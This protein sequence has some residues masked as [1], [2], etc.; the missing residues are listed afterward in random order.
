MAE[1]QMEKKERSGAAWIW[2]LLAVLLIA[3]LVWWLWP[4]RNG[5]VE[6]AAVETT[7]VTTAPL[8]PVT[9]EPT[10]ALINANP[11]EWVG[12]E[13]SGTVTVPEVPTDRGFWI[14]QDGQRLF[15]LLVDRESEEP[16]NINP[17]QRL[18]IRGTVRDATHLAQLQGDPLTGPTEE[19]VR[20]QP[21]YL[22]AGETA[23]EILDSPAQ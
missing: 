9:S 13:F 5:I 4:T 22:V 6:P 14:E 19:I 15:A 1:I 2:V 20:Q 3:L 10:L 7:T 16:I 23:I 12:R 11:Q 17:G 21:A 8:P 18:Q